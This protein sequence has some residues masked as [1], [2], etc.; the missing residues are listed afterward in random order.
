MM[1][2]YYWNEEDDDVIICPYCGKK[3]EPSY[4]ETYIG[5]EPVECYS[6]EYQEFICDDCKKRFSVTPYQR[7]WY[8]Q[9]ETIDGQMTNEEWEK[10]QEGE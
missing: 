5:G 7:G 1:G 4:E 9:T 3:Y 6:E 2:E 8:Y 10:I